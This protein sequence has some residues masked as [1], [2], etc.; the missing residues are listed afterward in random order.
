[1]HLDLMQTLSKKK[2]VL[3]TTVP[4]SADIE[5]MGLYRQPIAAALPHSPA[6]A[7]YEN[8]WQEICAHV[9]R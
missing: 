7:A 2:Q 5:R 4:F 8:L 3:R 1:M 6:A 9:Y